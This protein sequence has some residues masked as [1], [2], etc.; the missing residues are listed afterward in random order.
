MFHGLNQQ[1]RITPFLYATAGTLVK[2]L[3]SPPSCWIQYHYLLMFLM[4]SIFVQKYHLRITLL[5]RLK[6]T[7]QRGTTDCPHPRSPMLFDR[8]LRIGDALSP[9]RLWKPEQ[10][11]WWEITE[12]DGRGQCCHSGIPSFCSIFKPNLF[13]RLREDVSERPQIQKACIW[14]NSWSWH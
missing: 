7:R 10:I 11:H 12:C 8:R 4:L 5:P 13:L 3:F 1:Y 14:I 9:Q 6:D 2:V